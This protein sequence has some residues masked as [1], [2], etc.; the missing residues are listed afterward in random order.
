MSPYLDDPG[1]KTGSRILL[2]P[3]N[4]NPSS[5]KSLLSSSALLSDRV[6]GEEINR[7]SVPRKIKRTAQVFILKL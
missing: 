4:V 1:R 7:G 2:I 5:A 3:I 6:R